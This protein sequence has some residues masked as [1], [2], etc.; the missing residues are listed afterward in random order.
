MIRKTLYLV[1][2]AAV[3]VM[4]S[5]TANATAVTG[6]CY[7]LRPDVFA[8]AQTLPITIVREI[9]PIF[10]IARMVA[11]VQAV[12]QLRQAADKA[13]GDVQQLAAAARYWT[14][15]AAGDQIVA[16]KD[17]PAIGHRLRL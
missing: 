9:A 4:L 8:T 2:G 16:P 1:A 13:A 7:E 3:A 11:D 17:N 15:L 6:T 10:E 5:S 12:D 14:Y